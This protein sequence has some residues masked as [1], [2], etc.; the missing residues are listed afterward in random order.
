MAQVASELSDFERECAITVGI[1][2][3]DNSCKM[4]TYEK[5]V[6]MM[7]YH[8]LNPQKTDFFQ[9]DVFEK[10]RQASENPNA[11]VLADLKER[12][13]AAMDYITR[14]KMKAFK[15]AIRERLST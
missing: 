1:K 7:L 5:S 4:D 3:S 11:L 9:N 10:I 14:P 12:R 15:A 6:F 13:E 2:I 8:A